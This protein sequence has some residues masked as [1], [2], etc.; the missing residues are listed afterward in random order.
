MEHLPITERQA[1]LVRSAPKDIEQIT[2]HAL[3]VFDRLRK[4]LSE[5]YVQ[6]TW[7]LSLSAKGDGPL[8]EIV[9]P[10]GPIRMDLVPFVSDQGVQGRYLIQKQATSESGQS[11]WR[12]IWSLRI[13]TEGRVFQGD[14]ATVSVSANAPSRREDNEIV[15]LA[16]SILYVA[17]Q[18][19][20]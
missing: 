12:T 4:L 1:D 15:M 14:E 6:E 20:K 16:L 5:V 10:F 9:T 8:L 7:G 11:V 18:E 17:G 13:S 3:S 2:T 19:L